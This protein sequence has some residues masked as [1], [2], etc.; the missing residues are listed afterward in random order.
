MAA[1]RHREAGRRGAVM[2]VNVDSKALKDPRFRRMARELEINWHEALGLCIEVWNYA[3][4]ARSELLAGDDIDSIVDRAGVAVAML[5][6][7]L[8]EVAGDQLR[9]CGVRK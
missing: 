1:S 2:R 9:L 7:G 6:A 5:G 4:E 3:Y 8:A